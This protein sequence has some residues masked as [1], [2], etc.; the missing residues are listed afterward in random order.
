[1]S[2]SKKDRSKIAAAAARKAWKTMHSKPYIAAAKKS[3][4]HVTA[5]L[6]KRRAA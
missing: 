2:L 1:M 5:F 6:A 3:R 4:K